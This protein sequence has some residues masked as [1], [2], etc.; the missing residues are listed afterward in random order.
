VKTI[1]K[2]NTTTLKSISKR[3]TCMPSLK[4]IPPSNFLR[5]QE[6]SQLSNSPLRSSFARPAP[7]PARGPQDPSMPTEGSGFY[8]RSSSRALRRR[9]IDLA[10]GDDVLL[11]R[12]TFGKRIQ[13]PLPSPSFPTLTT[14]PFPEPFPTAVS[15][16]PLQPSAPRRTLPHPQRVL[17]NNTSAHDRGTSR[18][19]ASL[20]GFGPNLMPAP[21][22]ALAPALV[23]APVPATTSGHASAMGPP[24]AAS[25][26]WG[27]HFDALEV[28]SILTATRDDFGDFEVANTIRCTHPDASKQPPHEQCEVAIL[29]L[30]PSDA[31]AGGAGKSSFEKLRYVGGNPRCAGKEPRDLEMCWDVL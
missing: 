22:Q 23:P 4:Y 25:D 16:E 8:S 28:G 11:S 5:P 14:L 24:P 13:D 2:F 27:P 15:S 7:G 19:G 29:A 17:R 10:G 9:V 18:L 31:E 20:C 12:S 26:F 6:L 21:L 3:L 30:D 1:A